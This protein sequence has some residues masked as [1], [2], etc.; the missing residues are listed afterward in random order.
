MIYLLQAQSTPSV[1]VAACGFSAS[2]QNQEHSVVAG[3]QFGGPV[4]LAIPQLQCKGSVTQLFFL[5]RHL[6]H[7]TKRKRPEERRQV[8][9][10]KN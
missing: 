3:Q 6:L 1:L 5:H 9:F 8:K 10:V 7:L 4:Y 2:A